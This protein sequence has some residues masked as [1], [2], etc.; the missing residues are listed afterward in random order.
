MSDNMEFRVEYFN[1][2]TGKWLPVPKK[3]GAKPMIS[4]K[5]PEIVERMNEAKADAIGVQFRVAMR[6]CT[7]WAECFMKGAK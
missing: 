1:K 6:V 7:P 3:A 5:F 2:A 4:E